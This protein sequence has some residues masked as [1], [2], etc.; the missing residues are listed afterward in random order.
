MQWKQR[1]TWLVRME[2]ERQGLAFKELS[3]R[4][5]RLGV[6]LPGPQLSN[7]INRG[8]FSCAFFLQCMR[9]LDVDVI[10]LFDRELEEVRG[11]KRR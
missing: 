1:A 8:S 10:R 9:A 5:E 3:R 2:M 4:L 11:G 6:S 7:K